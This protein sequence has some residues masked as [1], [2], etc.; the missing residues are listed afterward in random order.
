MFIRFLLQKYKLD[1]DIFNRSACNLG[2]KTGDTI[3]LCG[4][5]IEL[6]SDGEFILK[7]EKKLDVF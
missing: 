5:W 1:L 4:L 6:M 2:Q 7:I 3:S